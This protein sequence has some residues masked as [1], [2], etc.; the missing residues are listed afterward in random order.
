MFAQRGS[1]PLRQFF[2]A[3]HSLRITHEIECQFPADQQ[4]FQELIG[5][6]PV[7]LG[8]AADGEGVGVSVGSRSVTRCGA[9]AVAPDAPMAVRMMSPVEKT[10]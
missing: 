5:D 8:V 3:V 10:P 9:V 2:E 7:L 6:Q 4:F 1:C